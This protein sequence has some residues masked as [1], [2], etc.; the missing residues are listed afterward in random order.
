MKLFSENRIR[1]QIYFNGPGIADELVNY[2][3]LDKEGQD[4][5]Y[6]KFYSSEANPLA[7]TRE[8]QFKQI[9]TVTK[10]HFSEKENGTSL[11][12]GCG[13]GEYV[14]FLNSHLSSN[15]KCFGIEPA[16]AQEK[17]NLK[18]ISI[19]DISSNSGLLPKRFEYISLLD[20][21]EHFKNPENQLLEINKI[22]EAGGL[23][24][25]KVPNKNAIF[26][27]L[28]KF[29]L[30]FSKKISSRIFFG[31]YQV[32]FPPPHFYYYDAESL[33]E[34]IEKYFKVEEVFYISECPLGGLWTRFWMVPILLRPILIVFTLMYRLTAVSKFND[35][36]VLVA[37]KKN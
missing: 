28:G 5:F 18:K 7:K 22:L 16:L 30:P 3:E 35:S 4:K 11:D 19:E 29:L 12:I 33:T 2:S 31:L 6:E 34:K 26:Y 23:L 25:L 37:T 8:I 10:E 9:F 1:G 36:L 24:I 13:R 27:K 15:W 32:N 17:E 20:V 21:F 14:S